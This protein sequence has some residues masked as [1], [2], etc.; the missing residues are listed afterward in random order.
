M[1]VPCPDSALPSFHS[2]LKLQAGFHLA[3]AALPRLFRR[4]SATAL[5]TSARRPRS[6]IRDVREAERSFDEALHRAIELHSGEWFTPDSVRRGR[7][8]AAGMTLFG[9]AIGEKVPHRS[10]LN[11]FAM[12]YPVADDIVDKGCFE[13]GTARKLEMALTGEPLEK[14]TPQEKVVV[15]LLEEVLR[16]YPVHDHPLLASTLLELHRLQLGGAKLSFDAAD[17]LRNRL[18]TGG[19]TAVAAGYLAQGGVRPDFAEILFKGGALLQLIDDLTDV[20]QDRAAG[21]STPFSCL[22]PGNNEMILPLS[23]L[24]GVK[25]HVGRL[26]S[27]HPVAGWLGRIVPALLLRAYLRLPQWMKEEASSLLDPALPIPLNVLEQNVRRLCRLS[28]H[29]L[30]KR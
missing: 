5:L 20:L 14:V 3:E 24:L 4:A 22:E 18:R 6:V 2:I 17:L 9:V 13:S 23:G 19:L 7:V 21:T 29:S 1:R 26:C 11:A 16:A 15:S 30:Q 27:S 25:A 10:A 12:L 28:G 8:A